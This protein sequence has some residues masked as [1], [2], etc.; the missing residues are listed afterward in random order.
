MCN[1]E[2]TLG[3]T[4]VTHLFV[5][6]DSIVHECVL[7]MDYLA[8]HASRMNF[9][10]RTLE[11]HF[12]KGTSLVHTATTDEPLR[13]CLST[14]TVIRP[15][16]VS[17]LTGYTASSDA[18]TI[19]VL[20]P[21]TCLY[22]KTGAEVAWS[23]A[24]VT[25]NV[26]VCVANSTNVPVTH[27]KRATLG[28]LYILDDQ[29]GAYY[30]PEQ[31]LGAS[32]EG[33]VGATCKLAVRTPWNKLAMRSSVSSC[34]ITSSDKLNMI[35]DLL[36]SYEDVVSQEDW[37]LGRT[38]VTSHDIDTGDTVPIKESPRRLPPHR[39]EVVEDKTT[40][41]IRMDVIRPFNS[42]WAAPIVLVKKKDGSL[43][44][45]NDYR[46]LNNVTLKDAF[47]LPRIDDTVEQLAGAMFF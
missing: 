43:W 11:M 17:F 32:D 1:L 35:V 34:N 21:R 42:P 37:D 8:K 33:M 41:M 30:L 40:E 29:N 19:A 38:T 39:R 7:G 36:Y 3:G 26:P 47:P 23:V 13:V 14:T 4:T 44:F 6:M 20:E 12:H 18:S 24:R 27:Y 25:E 46:R 10:E 15:F 5:I 28:L 16:A 22:K 45:C 9:G 31:S 2:I